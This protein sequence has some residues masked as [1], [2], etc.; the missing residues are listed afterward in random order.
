MVNELKDLLFH[1]FLFMSMFFTTGG[2]EG[3]GSGFQGVVLFLLLR[4]GSG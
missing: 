4:R 2:R 1:I 3:S